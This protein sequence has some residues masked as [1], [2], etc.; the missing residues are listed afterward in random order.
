MHV[1]AA[2]A[3]IP[4]ADGSSRDENGA[5]GAGGCDDC[6]GEAEAAGEVGAAA[7][8]EPEWVQAGKPECYFIVHNIAKKHNVGTMARCAT[9]F[10]IKAVVLIGAKSYNTFGCK[11]ASN[12]VDFAYYPTLK[13][14]RVGLT[15]DKARGVLEQR[16][17]RRTEQ[18]L[19]AGWMLILTD[20]RTRFVVARPS[21][22]HV[23]LG[24][25]VVFRPFNV[26]RADDCSVTLLSSG[27]A[28]F[29]VTL[30]SGVQDHRRGDHGGRGGDRGPSFRGKHGVHHGQRG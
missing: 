5:V 27:R 17:G 29:S 30:M 15:E 9:A 21:Y 7:A 14:A 18:D 6:I 3:E 13:D 12:H 20:V 19:P 23:T 25:L 4:L 11:G 24:P 8:A 16:L 1:N 2:A 10:G 22:E 26:C 28:L